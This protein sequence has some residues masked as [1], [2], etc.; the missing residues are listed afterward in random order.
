MKT[1][2]AKCSPLV[3]A[4]LLV[5]APL[6]LC[7]Q[8]SGAILGTVHDPTG[9]VISG[10]NVIVVNTDRSWERHTVTDNV[11]SYRVSNLTVGI[12][13]VSVSQAG[14]RE[15]T[16][17]NLTLNVGQERVQDIVLQVG[18]VNSRVDVQAQTE[19]LMT[20][21]SSQRSS[22]VTKTQ[23]TELPVVER[24]VT[25]LVLLSP[26]SVADSGSTKVGYT[27]G[28]QGGGLIA[29]NGLRGNLQSYE[30]DGTRSVDQFWGG[31]SFSGYNLDAIE[32]FRVTSNNYSAAQAGGSSSLT[33]IVTKSGTNSFHGS[34]FNFLS[35]DAFNAR[36]YFATKKSPVRI[37][38]FGG[39]FGGPIIKDKTFFFF[40]Y[41]GLRNPSSS[42]SNLE[43][44]TADQRN[45]TIQGI[46]PATG[47]PD[48]F[49]VPVDPRVVPI[50]ALYPNP[51]NPGGV[52]GA[53][54]YTTNVQNNLSRNQWGLRLDQH[55]SDKD[56]IFGRV[57]LATVN[58]LVTSP[59]G[60]TWNSNTQ[61]KN[62][63]IS[64]NETHLFTPSFTNEFKIG[65]DRFIWNTF[66]TADPSGGDKNSGININDG[67]M[68]N[69]PGG[70]GVPIAIHTYSGQLQDN[71]SKVIGRHTLKI[72]FS[73]MVEGDNGCGSGPAWGQYDF[74]TNEPIP[75]AVP[76]AS[77]NTLPAGSQAPALGSFFNFL[78]ANPTD[79]YL[80]FGVPG[81]AH[82]CT[83]TR[84]IRRKTIASYAQDDF[85]VTPRLTLNL[86]LRYEYATVI[87]DARK[88]GSQDALTSA[89]QL[90][91]GT[92]A[93]IVHPEPQYNAD[94]MDWGPFGPRIGFA[95]QATQST[96]IR[97]GGAIRSVIPPFAA[98]SQAFRSFPYFAI[99]TLDHPNFNFNGREWVSA[100]MASLPPITTPDG[101]PV[102][103]ANPSPN[104]PITILPYVP[105]VGPQILTTVAQNFKGGYVGDWSLTVEHRFAGD[106]VA[107]AAYVGNV[108]IGLLAMNWPYG[109]TSPG[110]GGRAVPLL[111]DNGISEVDQIANV[112]HSSYNG[113]QMSLRK[114]SSA[115][116]TAFQ[117]S[118]TYAKAL[119]DG[120]EAY[121]QR[122]LGVP[123]DPFHRNLE[124][125]PAPFDLTH[126]FVLNVVQVLPFDKISPALPSRLVKGWEVSGVLQAQTGY[127]FTVYTGRNIEDRGHWLRFN[128]SGAR[129]DEVG[130]PARPAGSA[131]TLWFN[132]AAFTTDVLP[133]G[134]QAAPGSLGRGT[135]R[136]P[137]LVQLDLGIHKD[138]LIA[139]KVNLQFRADAYNVLNHTN[140][141]LPVEQMTSPF[142]GFIQ[143]TAT[144]ARTMT[145]ALKIRF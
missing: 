14:F 108:G 118:Y 142:L 35:N 87:K 144:P 76:T 121:F 10:A 140:F 112:A 65:Y 75:A 73:I 60:K 95:Y 28:G 55:I 85:R 69:V 106:T 46:N 57:T 5:V 17:S 62:R 37:N 1:P 23:V 58:S 34:A 86:G 22:V 81:T 141:G 92:P 25:R 41:N 7:A 111:T 126:R 125:G 9:A 109:Y 39:V 93:I 6:R 115:F 120:S 98:I 43:V 11:G 127:P 67:S 117:A 133:D 42:L 135:L 18:D 15:I 4:F 53:N 27:A 38:D 48:T 122:D 132:P 107:S 45:G 16:I 131:P 24:D 33:Q 49:F 66:E 64:I 71:V 104:T 31:F 143:S 89:S 74:Q 70:T 102:N 78:M 72:G 137:H 101:N 21:T 113:L 8:I 3:L 130:D 91:K 54:T 2:V 59:F 116:G 63:D 123:Q 40:E 97:G 110:P 119:D 114:S 82:P 68:S 19:D 13:S 138:T 105:I 56:L 124:K 51:N 29:V 103:L 79:A 96:V 77:G 88:R 128:Q 145:L 84:D 99:T 44:P 52:F 20:L 32:E 136:G 47:N 90:W 50:L 30:I 139:E 12:Y 100:V 26:G 61:F 134:N 94:R 80:N 129:P 83:G 36:N